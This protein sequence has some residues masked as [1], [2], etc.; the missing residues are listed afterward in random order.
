METMVKTPKN[1]EAQVLVIERIFDAPPQRLWQAWT[2]PEVAKLW[3]GPE[4]FTAPVIKMDFRVGGKYH[5]CMRSP[6]GDDYWSAGVYHEIVPF[7]KIVSTDSFADEKG[8]VV[9]AE[10]YG[11]GSEFPLE[12]LVTITFEDLGGK[13]KQTL[14]HAGFPPGEHLESACS[15][16]STSFDKLARVLLT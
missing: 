11:M 2:D 3:W 15:G 5:F 1:T 12:L 9:S 7:E 8:N 4:H 16:W 6:E 13:T 10:Y 14:R